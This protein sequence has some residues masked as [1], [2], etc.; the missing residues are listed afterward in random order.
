MRKAKLHKN[1]PFQAIK[2]SLITE[3][4]ITTT[5]D[6]IIT[7]NNIQSQSKYKSIVIINI[8]KALKSLSLTIFVNYGDKTCIDIRIVQIR[9]FLISERVI[10]IVRETNEDTSKKYTSKEYKWD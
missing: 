2:R 7:A 9:F 3:A 10:K 8:D 6:N 4:G 1:P 5:M